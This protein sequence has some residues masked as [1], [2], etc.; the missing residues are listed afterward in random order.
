MAAKFVKICLEL[1]ELFGLCKNEYAVLSDIDYKKLSSNL[2]KLNIYYCS[3]RFFL[4]D[5]RY[6][7]FSDPIKKLLTDGGIGADDKTK[8]VEQVA[9]ILENNEDTIK[10]IKSLQLIFQECF[11]GLVQEYKNSAIDLSRYDKEAFEVGNVNK[12]VSQKQKLNDNGSQLYYYCYDPK[13]GRVETGKGEFEENLKKY[14]SGPLIEKNI[15]V[16]TSNSVV[17]KNPE[18]TDKEKENISNPTNSGKKIP[19]PSKKEDK[20][21]LS[22]W[23]LGHIKSPF[24][25]VPL[26]CLGVGV[27]GFYFKY[28]ATDKI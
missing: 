15:E 20:D 12:K 24:I 10:K 1:N 22:K 13:I 18:V 17:N 11:Y 23:F 21:S 5:D 6:V 26:V 8:I 14:C 25:L 7:Y 2:S 28:F 27:F 19:L 16:V 4:L 9:V 3:L